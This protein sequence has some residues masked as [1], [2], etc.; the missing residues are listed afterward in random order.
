MWLKREE[1]RHTEMPP[2]WR[3]IVPSHVFQDESRRIV[4]EA[5]TAGVVLRAM[6]GVAIR[7]HAM[8]EEDLARRLGR[9]G[10]TEQEFTDLDFAS[11]RSHRKRMSEFW[12]SLGYSKRRATLSSAASER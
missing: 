5:E 12:E 1:N 8:E 10:E 6:G 9:L 3:G 4:N 11:Y 7:L 2:E